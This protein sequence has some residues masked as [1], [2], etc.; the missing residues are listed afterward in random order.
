MFSLK[1]VANHPVFHRPLDDG[2][3][4]IQLLHGARDTER[5]FDA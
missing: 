2:I 4:V 5:V 3:E 1:R